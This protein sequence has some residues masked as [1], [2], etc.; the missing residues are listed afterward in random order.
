MIGSHSSM[1][2]W[3]P[4]EFADFRDA[5]VRLAGDGRKTDFGD[6]AW[7]AYFKVRA[8]SGISIVEMSQRLVDM[9]VRI[10]IRHPKEYLESVVVGSSRFFF[11]PVSE[12]YVSISKCR[13]NFCLEGW[14]LFVRCQNALILPALLCFFMA[15]VAGIVKYVNG[16]RRTGQ[17]SLCLEQAAIAIVLVLAL[18][19]G[20]VC[21]VDCS[22]YA[23]P[24]QPLM[25]LVVLCLFWRISARLL[26]ALCNNEQDVN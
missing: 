13:N 3:A 22:R 23:V 26:A 24:V 18:F 25:L 11:E 14:K 9:S 7:Q 16:V 19:T 17:W 4:D 5:Y 12:W 10:F 21:T 2:K 1:I 6:L 15:L 20:A 8:Q